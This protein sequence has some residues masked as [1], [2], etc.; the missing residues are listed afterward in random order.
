MIRTTKHTIKFSNTNKLENYDTFITEMRRVA[1]IFVD[2][3]WN[4]KYEYHDKHNELRI[5]DIKNK[6][7][8]IPQFFDYNLIDVETELSARALS[9]L[10]TQCCGIVK[11]CTEK[12]KRRLHI[13][14]E[15]KSNN[16]PIS[17]QLLENI[18]NGE[19]T[20]PNTN[21]I[22]IEISSKNSDF[23]LCHDEHFDA[24][25]RIKYFGMNKEDIKIPIKF[26]RQS[27]KWMKKAQEMQ[28]SF[29]LCNDNIQIRWQYKIEPKKEGKVVGADTGKNNIMTLGDAQ[30]A[31]R[32]DNH[33]YSMDKIMTKMTRKKYGSRNFHQTQKQRENFINWSL[34][35]LEFSTLKEVKLE[36]VY[37]ICYG[38]NVNRKM[39]RWTN[40]HISKRFKE[41]CEEHGVRVTEQS[42]AYRS[43]RCS[44]CGIVLA[45]NRKKENY[46]CGICGFEIDSD[47]NATKNHEV[48]LPE[49]PDFVSNLHLNRTEGFYWRPEG[50]FGLDG[51]EFRVPCSEIKIK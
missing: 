30:V 51:K 13:L 45:K 25:L 35:Q 3:M 41:L 29:L 36:R 21:K 49:V 28:H 46:S 43:Q 27:N 4:N 12:Q 6:H 16:E 15:K 5:M 23:K 31:P 40:A 32:T 7:Y 33:G 24:F 9:S 17:K 10:V 22:N 1:Q 50:F 2:Y 14:N 44:C 39:K 38:K 37:N 19:P 26:T 48:E 42:S 18:E 47:F 8:D 34:N 11:A 20:K